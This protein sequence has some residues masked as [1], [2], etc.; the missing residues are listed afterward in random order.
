MLCARQDGRASVIFWGGGQELFWGM[1]SIFGGRGV[2]R[3]LFL[4]GRGRRA[5]V[6]WGSN[7]AVQRHPPTMLQW[8][9]GPGPPQGPGLPGAPPQ[10]MVAQLSIFGH[11]VATHCS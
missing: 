10:L 7:G 11:S 3:S 8:G 5:A 1:I 2:S 6:L 9:T 4:G